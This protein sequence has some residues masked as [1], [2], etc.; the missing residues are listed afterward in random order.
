MA[1]TAGANITEYTGSGYA[2]YVNGHD[3]VGGKGGFKVVP[4]R[5]LV[6]HPPAFPVEVKHFSTMKDIIQDQMAGLAPGG[7]QEF[8]SWRGHVAGYSGFQ[9]RCPTMGVGPQDFVS[10]SELDKEAAAEG[11]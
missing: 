2:G 3:N 7:T 11:A 1:G 10:L 6:P 9:P 8:P 4:A 5:Y